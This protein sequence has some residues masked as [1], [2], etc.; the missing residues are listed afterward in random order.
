VVVC[1]ARGIGNMRIPRDWRDP[2]KEGR[3]LVLSP[4]P[5]NQR[6]PTAQLAARR[7]DHVSHL[8]RRVIIVHAAPCGRTE[9]FA[10]K[11]AESGKPVLTLD[12]PANANLM[13]M[14]ARALSQLPDHMV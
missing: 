3:F 2:L 11:L 5:S 9:A 6:R 13:Q 1:P 12:S 4:F 7:S 14:G 10:H 8:A